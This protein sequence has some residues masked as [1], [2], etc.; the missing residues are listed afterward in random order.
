[1]ILLMLHGGGDMGV[2]DNVDDK[3]GYCKILFLDVV[4]EHAPLIKADANSKVILGFPMKLN[5]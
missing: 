2:F 4:S 5:S 1:M 3:W